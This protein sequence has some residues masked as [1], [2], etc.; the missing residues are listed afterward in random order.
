MKIGRPLIAVAIALVCGLP[1]PAAGQDPL[2]RAKDYYASASYD[3]ALQVL[4]QLRSKSSATGTTEVAAYQMFCLVALGR[5]QEATTAIEGL[6]KQDP[7]YHPNEGDVSPRVRS[8]F[9][10]VR[11]PL[12][13]TLVREIYGTAK[14]SLDR[15][16]MPQAASD[17]DRVISLLDEMGTENDPG[18]ADLRTLA[19]G[20]RDLTRAAVSSAPAPAPAPLA[21]VEPAIP[22]AEKPAPRPEPDSRVY[23]PSDADVVAA[24]PVSRAMPA[25]HPVSP[26]DKLR[27][28]RGSIELVVDERGKVT[29]VTILQGVH[30]DYD[31]ALARA[32]QGWTFKPAT[33]D[34]VPVKYRSTI[35]ILLSASSR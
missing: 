10:T 9:E 11:R 19:V 22:I 8:F 1:A 18:L 3:E 23:G 27:N 21:S 32:A 33:R 30:A 6:V 13:P 29:K 28:F 25:W 16:D 5:S 17:F 35:E 12:L 4:N 20:F 14:A 34:G 15:K 24:V 7:L 31:M 26:V 2:A